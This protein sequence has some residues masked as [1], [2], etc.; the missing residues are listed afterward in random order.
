[1]PSVKPTPLAIAL[2]GGLVFLA[3]G[4]A[5]FA[6]GAWVIIGPAMASVLVL[7]ATD[8]LLSR[9]SRMMQLSVEAPP[10][11]YVGPDNPLTIKLD[12]K[13]RG[14]AT[15]ADVKLD[16]NDK[17]EAPDMMPLPSS[18]ALAYALHLNQRGEAIIKN[19]WL[20]WR[21]PFGLTMKQVRFPVDLVRPITPDIRALQSDAIRLINRE[22]D[23]GLKSQIDRGDGSEF[24]ALREFV[25]G[26]DRRSLDWKASAR[27]RTLMAKEFQT[28]RNHNVVLAYDTGRL[29]CE[30]IDGLSRLDHAVH[31]GML[32]SYASLRGGDRVGIYGFDTRPKVMTGLVRGQSAFGRLQAEMGRLDYSTLDANYTLGLT[33]LSSSLNRRSLIILFTDF[34]DTIQAE[35]MLE[36]AARLA[37]KHLLVFAVFEDT[38]LKRIAHQRPRDASDITRAVIAD[39]LLTNRKM[40][41]NRLRKIGVEVLEAPANQF[42]GALLSKY[43]EITRQERI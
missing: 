39:Q 40:V 37:R 3:L 41:H 29:M 1:M 27:H 6:P 2:M 25:S 13:G 10:V 9:S 5:A 28:E 23:F 12:Y 22:A 18:G 36:N 21:G 43:L 35:L 17:V 30:P 11:Y 32:L 16:V 4:L 26:M 8:A 34:I 20:R 19:V 31:A 24:D 33:R 38:D 14:A 7:I 42:S 15:R